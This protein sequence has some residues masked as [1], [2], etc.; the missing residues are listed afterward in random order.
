M[1]K[2]AESQFNL[3]KYLYI[4]NIAIVAI[5]LLLEFDVM[6]SLTGY[7][8]G[9]VSVISV[10]VCTYILILILE[11]CFLF[12][13]NIKNNA[14]L[15]LVII[16]M[17]L[18]IFCM[19]QFHPQHLVLLFLF[20]IPLSVAGVFWSVSLGISTG[21]LTGL[22]ILSS[23]ILTSKDIASSYDRLYNLTTITL[24]LVMVF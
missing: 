24:I 15:Y 7:E 5:G 22:C 18:I 14:R 20:S 19:V 3:F 1:S 9:T 4:L 6:K 16:G 23:I 2:K 11:P 8:T 21:I 13:I 12:F 17:S 10:P